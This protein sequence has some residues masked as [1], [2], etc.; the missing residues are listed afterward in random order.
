M[1]RAQKHFE[2]AINLDPQ[3]ALAHAEFGHLFLQCGV[4]GLMPPLD[5]LPL[6]RMEA[7]RAVAIDP[8]LPEGHA[9]LGTAAAMFDFDWSDA[10]R[11]FRRAMTHGVVTPLVIGTTLFTVFCQLGTLRKPLTTI[12]SA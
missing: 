3:F 5:A 12:R 11:H 4:Y 1:A 2:R 10:E 6:M 7:R 8:S 9:M